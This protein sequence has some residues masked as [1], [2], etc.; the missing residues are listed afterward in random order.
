LAG[1]DRTKNGYLI[2]ER[3][4]Q[5]SWDGEV[6]IAFLGDHESEIAVNTLHPFV[7]WDKNDEGVTFNGSY[8][9]NMAEA[10]AVYIR[11]GGR[12]LSQLLDEQ[13]VSITINEHVFS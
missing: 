9:A 4:S 2:L 3:T 1:R 13:E 7:V 10:A 12:F 8:C 11:R 5:R 6:I